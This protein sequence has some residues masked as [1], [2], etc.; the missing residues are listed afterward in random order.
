MDVTDDPETNEI[1]QES[2]YYPFGMAMDGQWMSNTGRENRYL[3]NDK[4]L[5]GDFGLDWY[6]YGARWYDPSIGRFTG[7]DPI[8]EDF[9]WVTTYNYAENEPI[10]N[11]DLWGLQKHRMVDGS[12]VVGPWSP[13]LLQNINEEI[14][15]NQIKETTVTEVLDENYNPKLTE[16]LMATGDLIG[17]T[18]NIF[19]A[20]ESGSQLLG[21]LSKTSALAATAGIADDVA[22]EALPVKDRVMMLFKELDSAN[23]VGN[24]DDAISLINKTLDKIEDAHSGVIKNPN[25]RKMPNIQDGR[26]YG[27]LDDKYVQ[28]F[29]DG[30]LRAFTRK[31]TIMANKD[32]GFSIYVRDRSNKPD[33]LGKLLFSKAG[34]SN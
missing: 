29:P 14:V 15:Y 34:K 9:P 30:G 22:K 12:E 31:N 13:E 21:G 28:R 27:I 1:L 24:A 20:A 18:L 23:P 33:Q 8:A 25:A 2:H 16:A 5:N 17:F 10:A 3:Y 26:M 6:D 11:I 4:E 32:G 7:V 19:M